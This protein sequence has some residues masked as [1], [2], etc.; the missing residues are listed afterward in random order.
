MSDATPRLRDGL[1][2]TAVV[3]VIVR[4]LLFVVSGLSV[5]LLPLPEGQPTDVPGWPASIPRWGWD[6]FFT[7]TERQDALW[8]LRIATEGYRTDDGSAAFFPLYP[9]AVRVL[10]QIPGVGP[11]AAALLVSNA[12]LFGALLVLHGLTRLELGAEHARRS[13]FL[14]A[15]FPTA[16]FL[17]APYTESLFLLLTLTAFWCA[18]RDRWGWAAL[19]GAGAAMTRSV[20]LVLIAALWV[21]AIRQWR[22]EGKAPLPRLTA[23]AVVA[24]GPALVFAWWGLAHGDLWA[25]LD[26]QRAWRPDGAVA[27]WTSIWRAIDHAWR[28]GSWW[29]LDLLIVAFAVGGVVLAVRRIGLTYTVYAAGSLALPLLLP[30]GGRP[31]LSVPRFM[32]VVFPAA[33]GWS[34]AVARGRPPEAAIVGIS[35]ALWGVVT[36]LFVGWWYVF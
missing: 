19:A 30:F 1:R 23:A 4:V 26:A 12:A 3:F 18:R 21:E 35:A 8:F 28:Y 10:D 20:G 9:L 11:L 14:V 33:W 16:C 13:A 29:A 2:D 36:V 34:L 15:L 25:P 31:L 7:A 5:G 17:L 6:A 22:R 24:V 32:A 27:P